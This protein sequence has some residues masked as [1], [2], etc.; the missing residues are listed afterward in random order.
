MDRSIEIDVL[1]LQTWLENGRTVEVIDIRPQADYQAWHVPGSVNVDAYNAIYANSPGALAD[2]QP[3]DGRTVV[4]VCFVG[5]TSKIAA[6]YLQSRRIQALSLTGGMQAWSL[7]WNTAEIPL[8]Q[9]SARVVQVRRTGKGCL[10]Y[11]VESE[12]QAVVIDPSVD[13]QVYVDLASGLGC[14]IVKVLDTHIHADHLSRSRVLAGLT[15]AEHYLP[16]QERVAFEYQAVDP[17]EVITVG[18]ARL[19]AI[20]SPGHTFESMSYLLDGRALF[21]GDT[22][23]L[24]S[25]GRPDLKADREET[26]ARTR[27]LHRTLA[28]LTALDAGITI[29]P[30]HTGQPVPFDKLPV[31]GRLGAIIEKVEALSFDEEQF[32]SWILERIPSDP[33]NYETIVRL[34]EMGVLPPLDPAMLE[35]GANRCAI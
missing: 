2:Y 29:L 33:P 27:A 22:L 28:E 13:A 18:S 21:S 31:A 20:Y 15:G 19:E 26:I 25:V 5:Q 30:C 14:R 3:Q 1:T 9:G 12:G 32:V 11:L 17:G 10:S 4:A 16:R 7:S 35:A 34:N 6:R 23:F 8:S 24:E